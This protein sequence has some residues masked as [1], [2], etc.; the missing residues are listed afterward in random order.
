MADMCL[1]SHWESAYEWD[2]S[3]HSLGIYHRLKHEHIY[4]TE[5]NKMRNGYAFEVMNH[6]MLHLMEVSVS[7]KTLTLVQVLRLWRFTDN[8]QVV[9]KSPQ[10]EHINYINTRQYN[11]KILTQHKHQYLCSKNVYMYTLYGALKQTACFI[12]IPAMEWSKGSQVDNNN[13]AAHGA[14]Y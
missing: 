2:R 9:N 7:Y 11:I 12:G 6:E 8:L 14:S 10:S 13:I 5:S 4:L 1:W 3:Q